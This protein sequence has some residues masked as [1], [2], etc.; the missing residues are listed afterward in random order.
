MD[1]QGTRP[2]LN[3]EIANLARRLSDDAMKSSMRLLIIISL[4]LNDRL[5]FSDLLDLTG[6][7]KGSLANHLNK[8]MEKGLIKSGFAF[9]LNGPVTVYSLTEEGRKVY[10][11]Y[12]GA[13]MR[14][15]IGK[16]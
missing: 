13:I 7:G 2:D 5:S 11:E 15:R 6:L 3:K 9:S 12:V 16:N 8:L 1:D 4:Y 10:T 14:M